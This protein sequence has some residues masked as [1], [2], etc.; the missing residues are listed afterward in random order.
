MLL[1]PDPTGVLANNTIP[2]VTKGDGDSP[3][4]RRRYTRQDAQK[5]RK[6]SSFV[7]HAAS[8]TSNATLHVVLI[9]PPAPS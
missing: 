4:L 9:G 6:E 2:R 7:I 1:I 3:R 5:E 8:D